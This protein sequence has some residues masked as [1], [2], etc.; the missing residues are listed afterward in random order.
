MRTTPQNWQRAPRPWVVALPWSLRTHQP[1]PLW[2]A[3]PVASSRV[4]LL[5]PPRPS[6]RTGVHRKLVRIARRPARVL[7]RVE[8][9]VVAALPAFGGGIASSVDPSSWM[10]GPSTIRFSLHSSLLFAENLPTTAVAAALPPAFERGEAPPPESRRLH[11]PPRGHTRC[12][13]A[14]PRVTAAARRP[15]T[16]V[17]PRPEP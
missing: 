17:G 3:G 10:A 13:R 2:V 5:S 9:V 15:D 8:R 16:W 1:S 4:R 12:G 6:T 11:T 14:P 7:V